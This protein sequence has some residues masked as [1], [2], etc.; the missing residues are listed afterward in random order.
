[1]SPSSKVI[2]KVCP[3]ILREGQK[4]NDMLVFR[5]P[6]AGSQIVKGT[7]EP[8]ESLKAA[9]IRE[10]VE[11]SGVAVTV[12]RDLGSLFM[13]MRI[14]T[15]ISSNV[16]RNHFPIAGNIG[17]RT[18]A[19]MFSA[20]IRTVWT[21]S[22]TRNGIQHSRASLPSSPARSQH[23]AKYRRQG[24][25]LRSTYVVIAPTSRNDT[26]RPWRSSQSASLTQ[27]RLSRM[28]SLPWEAR[29]GWSRSTWGSR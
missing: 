14:R 26:R 4:G 28:V 15:G 9:V 27:R 25:A 7:V 6:L 8:D 18:T 19:A 21:K 22:P 16:Y 11:E 23:N 3:V 12:K 2:E 1:M 17:P 5:H 29:I 10:M 24:Q 13:T 20:S